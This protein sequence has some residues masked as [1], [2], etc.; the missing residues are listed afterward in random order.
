MANSTNFSFIISCWPW[1]TE[2]LHWNPN[3]RK[4]TDVVQS[5]KPFPTDGPL[6]NWLLCHFCKANKNI[7]NVAVVAPNRAAD[8]D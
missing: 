6:T 2:E 5:H 3:F 7:T 4:L 8:T 1:D